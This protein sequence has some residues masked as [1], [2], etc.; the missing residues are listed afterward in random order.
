MAT[1]HLVDIGRGGGEPDIVDHMH[2]PARRHVRKDDQ[3][4]RVGETV[5]LLHP[6]LH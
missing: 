1:A 5:I 2:G 6:A 4:S 3:S